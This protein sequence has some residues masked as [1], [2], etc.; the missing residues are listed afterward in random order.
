MASSGARWRP[1]PLAVTTNAVEGQ[2]GIPQ[3]EN[4]N[5]VTFEEHEG[6]TPIAL[7]DHAKEKSR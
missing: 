7:L 6:G 1:E 3:L 2:A 4:L 5:T